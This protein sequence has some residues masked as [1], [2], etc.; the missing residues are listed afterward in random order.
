MLLI[1]N[2]VKKFIHKILTRISILPSHLYHLAFFWS[3][4]ESRAS[5]R[6]IRYGNFASE[7]LYYIDAAMTK[8]G[9][10]QLTQNSLAKYNFDKK[11][12]IF[13]WQKFWN[14]LQ[15]S[16]FQ[17]N[18][19][20][21]ILELSIFNYSTNW[22]SRW[23]VYYTDNHVFIHVPPK[24]SVRYIRLFWP[25]YLLNR[26]VLN[27]VWGAPGNSFSWPDSSK[28]MEYCHVGFCFGFRSVLLMMCLRISI[29]PPSY[30]DRNQE[31]SAKCEV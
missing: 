18:S 15:N 8:F 4:Q 26:S 22:H 16:Q 2:F 5:W 24:S 7:F 23:S 19:R 28:F 6:D 13:L 25:V 10:A 31:A 12:L 21:A 20:I 14:N 30:I 29:F 1:S 3:L 17:N 9:G 11:E 27:V